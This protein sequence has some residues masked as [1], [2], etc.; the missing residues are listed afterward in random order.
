MRRKSVPAIFMSLFCNLTFSVLAVAVAP[1][2]ALA[3]DFGSAYFPALQGDVQLI[4]TPN[5]LGHPEFIQAIQNAVQKIDMVMYHLTDK[6]VAQALAAA[7]ERG[8]AVRVIV[9]RASMKS[10]GY[11]AAYNELLSAHINARPS[12]SGFNITHQKTIVVDDQTAFV[13]A[14]NLTRSSADSRDF[15]VI[16]SDPAVVAE[17]DSVFETDWADYDNGQ[18]TTPAL[19]NANLAW[20]PVSSKTKLSQLISSA[21]SSIILTTENLGDN[22]I[23]DLL[24]A[25]AAR[26]VVVQIIVPQCDLNPNPAYNIPAVRKVTSAGVDA[27]VMPA[28]SSPQLPYMHSKM[29]VIDGHTVY[30]GSINLSYNSLTQ[31]RELGIIFDSQVIASQLGAVFASDWSL[32]IQAPA[33]NVTCPSF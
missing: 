6:S 8:V 16:V 22:D 10:A 30:I 27:R 28:P 7:V 3:D 20:S 24:D 19:S 11:Q 18:N 33:V 29:M 23:T 15:G 17:M 12:S 13:T 2:A 21:S 4:Q 14:I 25:A 31:A 1:G 5:P 26:G 9:D 32:A